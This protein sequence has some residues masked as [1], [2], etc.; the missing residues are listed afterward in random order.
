MIFAPV[1]FT[2]E[3]WK[4]KGTE[5]EMTQRY[6]TSM[7]I[8]THVDLPTSDFPWFSSREENWDIYIPI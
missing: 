3:K 2:E 6:H 7:Y 1:I 4:K 5:D 8:G